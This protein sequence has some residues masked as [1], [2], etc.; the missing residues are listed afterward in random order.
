MAK[1]LSFLLPVSLLFVLVS[2][3]SGCDTVG[4]KEDIEDVVLPDPN[5]NDDSEDEDTTSKGGLPTGSSTN[6]YTVRQFIEAK[7][8]Y[9]VFVH[10]YIVG[11]CT[12]SISNA[13]FQ[14]PFSFSQA[15]LLADRPRCQDQ[16]S[17]ISVCLTTSQRARKELNLVDHPENWGRTITVFGYKEKYLGIIGIKNINNAPPYLD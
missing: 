7:L 17:I 13:E 11:D 12:V 9:Q 4:E 16:D 1:L 8:P 5:T 14:P 2:A 3:I 10:G 15:V 6:I